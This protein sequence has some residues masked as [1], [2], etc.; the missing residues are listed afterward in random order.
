MIGGILYILIR[1]VKI[2]WELQKAISILSN[3]LSQV[4]G[5]D[6][7]KHRSINS[8]LREVDT[9]GFEAQAKATELMGEWKKQ[10]NE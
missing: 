7:S 2:Q 4:D 5:Y 9:H 10:N 6:K 1:L 8:L 3:N